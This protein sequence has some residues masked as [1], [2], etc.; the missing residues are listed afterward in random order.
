MP[1]KRTLPKSSVVPL[2][3]CWDW[4]FWQLSGESS[5]PMTNNFVGVFNLVTSCVTG[6]WWCDGDE[7]W[8]ELTGARSSEVGE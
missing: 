4:V 1:I 7:L 3:M 2:W 5:W 6:E 8:D